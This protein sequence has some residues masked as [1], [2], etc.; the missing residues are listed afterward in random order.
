LRLSLP[1]SQYDMMNHAHSPSPIEEVFRSVSIVGFGESIRWLVLRGVTHRDAFRRDQTEGVYEYT[2]L[3]LN[4][5]T[6]IS[7]G[8]E[9]PT[10]LLAIADEVIE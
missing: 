10:S 2:P 5:K 3:V 1:L 9:L 6:A 4:R 8:L 7:L